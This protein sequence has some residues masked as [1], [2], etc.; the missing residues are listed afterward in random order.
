VSTGNGLVLRCERGDSNPHGLLHWILSP[1]TSPGQSSDP[2]P[3]GTNRFL[4]APER[5]G[6]ATIGATLSPIPVC[7][8]PKEGGE[9]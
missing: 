8:S 5:P 9:E 2:A 3:E 6:S 4:Q 7:V 1:N